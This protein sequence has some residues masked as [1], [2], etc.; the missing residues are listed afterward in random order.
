[1][2]FK[3]YDLDGNGIWKNLLMLMKIYFKSNREWKQNLK[4]N[5][6][7]HTN[8]HMLTIQPIKNI[9]E[10]AISLVRII[11]IIFPKRR[12]NYFFF[13]NNS[14]YFEFQSEIVSYFIL[15]FLNIFHQ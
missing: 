11:G 5:F 7:N 8:F 6:Y 3:P 12:R 13:Q 14:L 9:P 4:N 10:K 2:F 1:M 15:R